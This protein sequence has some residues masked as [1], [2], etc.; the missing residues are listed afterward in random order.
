M[1]ILKRE[2]DDLVVARS[3]LK[4]KFQAEL[5]VLDDQI[6]KKVNVYKQIQPYY[7]KLDKIMEDS[8]DV[9]WAGNAVLQKGRFDSSLQYHQLMEKLNGY[10]A[11]IDDLRFSVPSDLHEDGERIDEEIENEFEMFNR[12]IRQLVLLKQPEKFI[13]ARRKRRRRSTRFGPPPPS[14]KRR[15]VRSES[16]TETD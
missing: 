14:A 3:K 2:L 10:L 8:F 16:S 5:K 11:R 6:Q 9:R 1:S 12:L 7:Q 4:K 15:R 13:S